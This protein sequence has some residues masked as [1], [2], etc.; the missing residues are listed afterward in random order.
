MFQMIDEEKPT[1]D[2]RRMLFYKIGAF[3]AAIG[4]LGAI[5][6]FLVN[7]HYLRG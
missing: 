3:V 1:P 7:S 6:Y 5:A 2:S 4:A